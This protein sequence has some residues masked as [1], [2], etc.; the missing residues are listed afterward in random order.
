LRA[1]ALRGTFRGPMTITRADVLHVARLA[2]LGLEEH[3]L[4]PLAR[5]LDAIVG[6][7]N[8]LREVDT[9]GVTPTTQIAVERAPLRPDRVERGLDHD[10]ALSGAART[11]DG[12]FAVPAFVDES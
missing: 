1:G 12:A 11:G 9:E 7:V 2:R 5:E 10:A 3:E 4:G 8:E 6:Y